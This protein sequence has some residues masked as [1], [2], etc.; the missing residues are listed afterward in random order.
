[1]KSLTPFLVMVASLTVGLTTSSLYA[2]A[3]QIITECSAEINATCATTYQTCYNYEEWGTHACGNC[4]NGFFDYDGDCYAIDDIGTDGFL[5]LS[6]LLEMYLPEYAD[7]D[8]S[9]EE[10]AL[11]LGVVTRITSFWNSRVPPPEFKLGL[12]KETFLTVD[13]IKGRLGI[14]A[15]LGYDPA[16]FLS[17]TGNRG[18]MGRFEY[19]DSTDGDGKVRRLASSSTREGQR[20]LENAVDWEAQGYTTVI[21]NQ[22]LCGCC[23]AVATAGAVESALMITNQ[24]GRY[25]KMNQNS[26]SFQ[27]MISCDD[28]ELGCQGGNI[29][30]ATRYIWEHNQF[31]NN[32]FGGLFSYDDW[33]YSDFKG[34]TTEECKAESMTAS[35]LTPAAYLNYPKVVNS[36]NDRSD[37]NERKERLMTAVAVQPVMSVLK[38][39]CPILMNYKEGVLT[40]DDGCECGSTSC[41][42]HAVVIVGYDATA[43]TPYWKL[44][45]SWGAGWGESGHFRV[46][47]N[48]PGIAEWGLFGMLAESAMPSQAYK[49]LDDLPERPGWWETSQ[50][51]EKTL[52]ILF[53]ILGFCCLCSC[54]GALW[55]KRS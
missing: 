34:K 8:V 36:V 2:N 45:N 6:K 39:N 13:E 31:N 37:F 5:L 35:G 38:S 47:M 32:N 48:D 17:A 18:E 55:K 16:S 46:A 21:K 28:K 22:G 41:I 54:L 10:R 25:D 12:T 49:N 1:M 33:P 11:R 26:L 51:W 50:T 20:K 43:P 14:S 23:W 9:T 3:Q 7:P 29:L 24:T 27:Q 15:D 19:G 30:Q 40:H 44:R 42:D 53:S 4:L 52:V